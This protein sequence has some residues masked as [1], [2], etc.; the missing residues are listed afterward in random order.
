[1]KLP[2]PRWFK[3]SVLERFVGQRLAAAFHRP[4]GVTVLSVQGLQEVLHRA[5]IIRHLKYLTAL[6]QER[7]FARAAAL[8]HVTQP[9]LS[10]GIKQLEDSLGVL[11]VERDQHYVG[12]TPEGDRALSWAHRTLND[13]N[14]LK[15]ELSE[16]RGTLAGRLRIGVIPS[17][18]P[19]VAHLTEPLLQRHKQTSLLVKSR[20]PAEI[21]RGLDKFSLDIGVTYL[22]NN[23]LS[24]VCTQ[25]L[26]E[27][28]YVLLTARNLVPGDQRSITWTE[29]AK[30]PM[31]LLSSDKQS[32]RLID[33]HFHQVGAKARV[34][35]ETNSLIALWSE[36]CIGGL[37]AVV[38]EGFLPLLRQR[39]S[40]IV[41]PL[42]NPTVGHLIGLV[43]PDRDPLPPVTHALLKTASALNLQAVIT[44]QTPRI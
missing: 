16:L 43:V 12:L 17:A 25:P 1:M 13:Y 7:H 27:E 8:C 19:I 31:C 30:H 3:Q 37:S 40:L 5:M 6:A 42:T 23:P 11:L 20:A 28:R 36:V 32:R 44:E 22:N 26:Y 15:Q 41:M 29:A 34:V 38:P 10:A 35:V 24:H 21:Q 33:G 39:K 14:G 2:E 9:A 18:L 4:H